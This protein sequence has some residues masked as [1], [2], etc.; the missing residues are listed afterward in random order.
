LKTK[1][2]SNFTAYT[3]ERKFTVASAS[4]KSTIMAILDSLPEL[5]LNY[6]TNLMRHY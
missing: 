4:H 1:T 3:L 5:Q 2:T 6:C